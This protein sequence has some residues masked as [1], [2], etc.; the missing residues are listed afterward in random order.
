MMESLVES[1]V[2]AKSLSPYIY[3]KKRISFMDDVELD[4]LFLE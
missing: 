4:H 1:L 2:Y 3:C